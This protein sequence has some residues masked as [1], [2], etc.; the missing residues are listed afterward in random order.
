MKRRRPR[1][2]GDD[3]TAE[4]EGDDEKHVKQL[5]HKIF[6]Y[7]DVSIGSVQRLYECLLEANKHALTCS[8][9]E[10]HLHIH[11]HGGD[12]CAGFAAYHHLRKNILPIVTYVDGM[13]C[14]AA[15]FLL[16]AGRR[17]V[18]GT[19]G[20]VLIHQISTGFFG[21]YND[22]IDELQN[23][24]DLMQACRNLYTEH[25]TMSPERLEELLKSER[26]ISAQVCLEDGIVHAIE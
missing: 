4:E 26:A 24:K 15:T 7:A 14:S 22:M 21:K 20:F 23:T 11:S 16:M 17:R 5:H 2:G 25:T 1:F 9:G 8:V 19:H 6:F 13:V 10:V 3:E 18:C 12:A